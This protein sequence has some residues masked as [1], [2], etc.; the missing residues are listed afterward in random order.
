MH[1]LTNDADYAASSKTQFLL[2]QLV[3]ELV[4]F[5]LFL[6]FDAALELRASH[7]FGGENIH[8]GDFGLDL[9]LR[10]KSLV[11]FRITDQA[12]DTVAGLNLQYGHLG[13]LGQ[14]SGGFG[15]DLGKSGILHPELFHID[16]I[17]RKSLRRFGHLFQLLVL[18]FLPLL[19]YDH[20]DNERSDHQHKYD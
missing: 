2:A 17:Q 14:S 19:S 15:Y 6:G 13:Q 9:L 11:N 1:S 3:Q 20:Q 8:A 18:F 12:H 4:H 16:N 10:Q 7:V 5:P